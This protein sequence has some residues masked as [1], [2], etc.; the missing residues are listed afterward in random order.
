MFTTCPTKLYSTIVG[1]FIQQSHWSSTKPNSQINM[2]KIAAVYGSAERVLMANSQK[3]LRSYLI[4]FY[5]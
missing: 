4:F 2:C 1:M 3:A 5:T